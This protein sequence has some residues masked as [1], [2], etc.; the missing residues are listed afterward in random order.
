MRA[1]GWLHGVVA[2]GTI[3]Y[4]IPGDQGFAVAMV[5]SASLAGLGVIAGSERSS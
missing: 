2:A 3:L 4:A 1:V 5:L